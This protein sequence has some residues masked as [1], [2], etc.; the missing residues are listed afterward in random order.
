MERK[1]LIEFPCDFPLKIVGL[2]TENFEINVLQIIHHHFSDLA[3]NAIAMRHSKNKKYLSLT[4]TVKAKSQEQLDDL[5]R[6]LTK[7][8]HVLF[9]L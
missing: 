1:A 3:E 8:P 7:S 4:V 6:D 2:A 5:Y 9:A